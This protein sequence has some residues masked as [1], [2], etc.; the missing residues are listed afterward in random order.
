MTVAS[1]KESIPGR[2]HPK[3]R[4]GR[5]RAP[6]A[7]RRRSRGFPH[8]SLALLAFVVVA[9]AASLMVALHR[10]STAAVVALVVSVPVVIVLLAQNATRNRNRV[11][12][13]R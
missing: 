10:E 13:A 12:P 8:R 5:Q 4:K 6:L 3:P 9:L 1:A 7:V 2:K 11:R